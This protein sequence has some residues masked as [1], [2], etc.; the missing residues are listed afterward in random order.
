MPQYESI[1]LEIG[2]DDVEDFANFDD[3]AV[4]IFRTN[5]EQNGVK[6]GHIDKLVRAIN[7][8]RGQQPAALVAPLVPAS[9]AWFH[10]E[11]QVKGGDPAQGGLCPSCLADAMAAPTKRQRR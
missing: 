7:N 4:E 2:Y 1:F 11:C 10:K 5:L 3:R 9:P 8:R 6:S